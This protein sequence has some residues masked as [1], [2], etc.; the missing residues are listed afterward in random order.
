VFDSAE[1]RELVLLL[2][3]ATLADRLI[4]VCARFSSRARELWRWLAACQ[5]G[6]CGRFTTAASLAHELI[7]AKDERRLMRFQKMLSCFE[8]HK[9]ISAQDSKP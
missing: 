1:S 9:S 2:A 7:E 5:K 8:L 6:F 4:C 3:H